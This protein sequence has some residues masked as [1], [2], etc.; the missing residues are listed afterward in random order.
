MDV[1]DNRRD[2]I[3][4]DNLKE[5]KALKTSYKKCF[6]SEDGKKVIKDLEKRCFDKTTTFTGDALQTVFQEG[7]RSMLLHI[8]S[9][10]DMSNIQEGGNASISSGEEI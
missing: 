5:L 8:N 6:E 9:M 2:K 3:M 4:P 1:S 7:T 10:R